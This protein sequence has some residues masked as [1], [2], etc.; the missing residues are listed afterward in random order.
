MIGKGSTTAILTDSDARQILAQGFEKIQ[1]DGKRALVIIP[2]NTRTAPIP[3]LFKLL[4]EQ[5]GA[6]VTRLDYLIALGTHPPMSDDAIAK[7]VGVTK[8]ERAAKYPK[9][10]VFNHCWDDPSALTTLGT[11][12]RQELD[13]LT[14]GLLAQDT[15]VRLN[16]LVLEYDHILIVGPVFPHEVVG[17]S[18]GAKYLFPGI[19]GGEIIDFTHWLAALVT[20]RKTIGVKETAVRRV[21]H[22]A[23]EFLP[24][25]ITC[26]ALVM[27]GQAFHGLYIGSHVEAWSAAADLSAQLNIVWVERPFTRVLSMP[28]EM[29]DELW[30][31]GKAMYKTEPAIADGGEVVIYA[32]NL[33]TISITHGKLIERVGYHP[34]EYFTKQP[35]KFADV[36]GSIKAHSTHVKGT[37][38]FDPKTGVEIPR[39]K[40]TLASGIPEEICKRINLG[41]L[42]YRTI[43]PQEWENRER[44][45]ILV[46]HHAGEM[47]YRVKD[48]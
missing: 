12:T 24:K 18:G 40:V 19:A 14:G 28:S 34:L 22:R 13:A 27:S 25:P 4:Y 20:N 43:N 2:D 9:S 47:L 37:G 30:T 1:L 8:E 46:V 29:Y 23:A 35:D 5:L 10:Q 6:R 11:I 33:N 38:S 48:A 17:F 44:E 15:P 32:P 41:Y 16:K 45:G 26:V 31:A 42:D 7:L 21:I 3:L 36:P 39:I